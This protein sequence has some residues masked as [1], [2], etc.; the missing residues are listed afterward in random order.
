M[1]DVKKI[2]LRKIFADSL[3]YCFKNWHETSLFSIANMIFLIIGFKI[4]NAW[5]DFIFLLWL[6]PYYMF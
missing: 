4:I 6:V 1:A 2:P 5:H 3:D